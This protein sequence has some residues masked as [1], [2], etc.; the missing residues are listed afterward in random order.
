MKIDLI[1]IAERNGYEQCNRGYKKKTEDNTHWITFFN[2]D[3]LQMYAYF[4]LD[5]ECEKIYDTGIIQVSKSELQTLIEI[6]N[7]NHA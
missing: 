1:A 5:E 6:L 3:E 7:N 2:G 4:T